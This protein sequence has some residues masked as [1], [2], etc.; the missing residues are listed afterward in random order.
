MFLAHGQRNRPNCL[1]LL[2]VIFWIIQKLRNCCF[3]Y[4][5]NLYDFTSIH[6]ASSTNTSVADNFFIF[7]FDIC[8]LFG[9]MKN[10]LTTQYIQAILNNPMILANMQNFVC[11]PKINACPYKFL[12][13]VNY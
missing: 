1:L 2:A 9:M 5:Y 10:N 8:V 4:V 12:R 13:V 6:S 7:K 11:D 3:R